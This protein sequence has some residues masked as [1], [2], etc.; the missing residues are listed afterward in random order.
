MA[1]KK[2]KIALI[3]AGGIPTWAHMPAYKKISS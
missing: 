2:I 3:G 1:D